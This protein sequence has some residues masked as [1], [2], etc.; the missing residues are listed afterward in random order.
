MPTIA[1]IKGYRLYFVSFDGSEPIHV[2]VQKDHRGAKVWISPLAF[3]WSDFR[4][5]ENN[6]ILRIIEENV[7]LIREKWHE[8]FGY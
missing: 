7:P 2:H 4:T 6:A 3:A 8:H 1:C 5:H